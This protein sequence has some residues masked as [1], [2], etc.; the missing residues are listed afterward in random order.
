MGKL[1]YFWVP[2][3]PLVF[4][5]CFVLERVALGQV[6]SQQPKPSSSFV[7]PVT[8]P[9]GKTYTE[10]EL[11]PLHGRR[12]SMTTTDRDGTKTT[13]ESSLGN[14][15]N[16]ALSTGLYPEGKVIFRPGGAGETLDDGALSM[17]FGWWRLVP[18]Q[19]TIGG[20]RLDGPAPPLW[21]RVPSGYG[22]IGF[23]ATALIFP[24]PG[25]WE[26]TGRIGDKALT[27]VTEVVKIGD[28]PGKWK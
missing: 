12:G 6:G 18:G 4:A 24:T 5:A 11:A 2:W 19:L 10:A 15:G 27:F 16:E 1:R 28:G 21:A 9:N 3:L 8:A 17:K 14:H 23:Q 22:G 7:C 25:C 20:R 13:V 26:V